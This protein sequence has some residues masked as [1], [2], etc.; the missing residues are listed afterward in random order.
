MELPTVSDV[1]TSEASVTL[2]MTI[3]DALPYFKGHFPN[4]PILPGVALLNWAEHF[5][6][7][8]F[9][10]NAV[11]KGVDNLKF[12]QVVKPC[13]LLN[14]SL[15]YNQEKQSVQFE[16]TS[17]EHKHASGRILFTS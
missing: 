8:Y 16:Y 13:S 17:P 9:I 3:D 7:Q 11:F 6:K 1:I 5:A 14:L 4:A 12:Q 2:Q 15:S 10:L